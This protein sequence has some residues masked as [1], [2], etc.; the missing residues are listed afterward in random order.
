MF[1]G[2]KQSCAERAGIWHR[3]GESLQVPLSEMSSGGFGDSGTQ[4]LG[5]LIKTGETK[6][7]CLIHSEAEQTETSAFGAK[8]GLLQGPSKDRQLKL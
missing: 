6:F 4:A 3:Q 5:W 1:L 2:S 7:V 8:K